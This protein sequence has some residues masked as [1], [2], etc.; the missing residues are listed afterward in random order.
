MKYFLANGYAGVESPS[1]L[2]DQVLHVFGMLQ[3]CGLVSSMVMGSLFS[4]QLNIEILGN[5]SGEESET[6]IYLSS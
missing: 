6:Q 3:G 4:G 5:K 1:Y 2:A